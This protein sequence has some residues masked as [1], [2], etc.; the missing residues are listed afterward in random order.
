M[1]EMKRPSYTLTFAEESNYLHATVSGENSE[2]AV[3]GYL[4]ELS[5]VSAWLEGARD[6]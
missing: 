3:K 4:A 6:C 1:S 5:C 2:E